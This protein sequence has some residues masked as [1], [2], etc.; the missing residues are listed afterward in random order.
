MERGL[1]SPEDLEE[2]F[3]RAKFTGLKIASTE[4]PSPSA[5]AMIPPVLVPNDEI[6]MIHY[7]SPLFAFPME[8]GRTP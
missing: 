1:K 2:M 4:K 5:I 6:E 7:A 8:R 3:S